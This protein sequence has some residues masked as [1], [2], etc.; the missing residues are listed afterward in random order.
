MKNVILIIITLTSNLLFSQDIIELNNGDDI[1]VKVTEISNKDVKYK[2]FNNIEGPTY[3]ISKSKILMIRYENGEKEIIS[4][5]TNDNTDLSISA[6]YYQGNNKI[7]KR[8]F[9]KILSTNQK[10]YNEYKSGN[11]VKVLGLVIAVPSSAFLG[12]SIGQGDVESEILIGGGLG[13]VGGFLAYVGGNSM[14]KKSVKTYNSSK[15]IS[16][17][18]K[19]NSN[20]VGF[21]IN[22]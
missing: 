2:K 1:Q 16:Y 20:G 4:K 12:W 9:K 11:L 5:T 21:A 8:E 7:S 10:A 17:E 13:L 15:S 14:V 3:T 6:G 18:F 19:V 22:F